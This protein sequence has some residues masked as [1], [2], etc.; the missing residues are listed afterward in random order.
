MSGILA[1]VSPL[2]P[3]ASTC[4][5]CGPPGKR[6]ELKTSLHATELIAM[7]CSCMAYQ[8]MIDRGW[9]RSGVYCYKPDLM[10]SCCPQYTIKLD[11]TRFKPSKSQ[12]KLVNRFN[13]WVLHGDTH[14]DEKGSKRKTDTAKEGE[15]SLVDAIHHVESRLLTG[16]DHA[17]KFEVTLEPSSYT[18]EKFAL[19][20]RYQ[21]DIH[22]EEEDKKAS[23]FK[24]FLVENPLQYEAIPYETEPPG[25]L[26]TQYGAYHQCYR[27]DGELI[28]VGVIDILPGCVS[29]V[30]F[31]YDKKWEKFSLGKL[32]ALRE[33]S[34][35]REMH[36]AGAP[37]MQHLYMGFYIHS[38]PKMRYKG[39]YA[40]SYL[41]DPEEYTWHPLEQCASALDHV[42]YASFAHPEH[43]IEGAYDGPAPQLSLTDGISED[44]FLLVPGRGGN[45]S[46]KRVTTSS[47]WKSPAVKLAI[48][49]VALGMGADLARRVLFYLAHVL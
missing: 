28:A 17:H 8:M 4:G 31:M 36:D 14:G 23:S 25:H 6:S 32:S 37:G 9:R 47:D 11:A 2:T 46:V 45:H 12:R 16:Q 29:S 22:K 43:N 20:R 19:Y 30:Y 48:T 33:T 3:D 49:S 42:R 18:D 15:F 38:C 24:R 27:L 5:Y 7:D 41:L 1:I 10:R 13:R 26:P 34:L 21:K 44:L 40:P 39:E 35:V